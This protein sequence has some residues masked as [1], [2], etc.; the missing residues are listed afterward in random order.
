MF[1][2]NIA[3]IVR[4]LHTRKEAED[5]LSD[6]EIDALIAK[7]QAQVVPEPEEKKSVDQFFTKVEPPKELADQANDNLPD[8]GTIL[9]PAEATP[10]TPAAPGG[11]GAPDGLMSSLF[12]EDDSDDESATAALIKSLPDVSTDEIMA[13]LQQ[14]KEMINNLVPD[15]VKQQA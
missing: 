14:V 13:T 1:L 8:L 3:E 6:K 9:T 7:E 2:D 15:G 10:A 4:K 11:Q 12:A 5:D